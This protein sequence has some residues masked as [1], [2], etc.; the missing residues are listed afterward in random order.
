M[1]T[2]YFI[3]HGSTEANQ[4]GL[5]RSWGS[6][7]LDSAGIV[8]AKKIGELL[9]DKGISKVHSSD[10]RRARETANYIA[11]ASGVRVDAHPQLKTW[12]LGTLSGKKIGAVLPQLQFHSA[13]PHVPTPNGESF[14][15]FFDR[16]ANHLRSLVGSLKEKD[17]IAIVGHGRHMNGLDGLIKRL[18]GEDVD[19][20]KIPVKGGPGPGSVV[21]LTLNGSGI[22]RETLLEGDKTKGVAS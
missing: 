1:P 12:N 3:R 14:K 13:K 7:G 8:A 11:N 6:F 21:K 2:I 9:K 22:K 5:T 20:T 10:L 4:K 17:A 18:N 19:L 15:Q 16:S